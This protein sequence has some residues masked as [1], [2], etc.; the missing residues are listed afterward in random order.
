MADGKKKSKKG[1]MLKPKNQVVFT[2]FAPAESAEFAT[3][4]MDKYFLASTTPNVTT[5]LLIPLAP[6]PTGRV[7]L[8]PNGGSSRHPLLP[9]SSLAS[10]HN[11][12]EMHSL[13]VSSLFSRLD[14]ANVWE[15]GAVCSSY[16]SHADKHGVCTIL[17][18]DFTG[19]TI[20][21]VR[22]VIGEAGTGWCVLE[23]ERTQ[24]PAREEEDDELSDTSSILSGISGPFSVP[25]SI[26]LSPRSVSDSF[27]LP[28]LDFSSSFLD[29]N[30]HE[31]PLL[32]RTSST[33]DLFSE[34]SIEVDDP[35]S[36][37]EVSDSEGSRL[38]FSYDFARRS[39]MDLE[40]QY[41]PQEDMF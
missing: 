33:S 20:T 10:M 36:D 17:K 31:S 39:D 5:H 29:S 19:W 34:F 40:A 23:E 41:R 14:V 8:D 12:H 37:V 7:P 15:R 32:S 25:E 30:P 3:Q 2:D 1:E 6:T 22:S 16:A 11:E 27:V 38:R 28:T 26:S 9:L 35:W 4:D 18:I 21:E 24:K 13:R